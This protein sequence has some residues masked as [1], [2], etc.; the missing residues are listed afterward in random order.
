MP[1]RS[2]V[3]NLMDGQRLWGRGESLFLQFKNEVV[4][5]TGRLQIHLIF[6]Y[7]C[8][9]KY[10]CVLRSPPRPDKCTGPLGAEV[11]G[12]R[13]LPYMGAGN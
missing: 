8:V 6:V 4:I 12:G 13:R 5:V 7:V 2:R 3:E 11:T 1:S 10:V 9:C